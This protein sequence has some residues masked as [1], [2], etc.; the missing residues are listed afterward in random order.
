VR[1]HVR[2]GEEYR[3]LLED[4]GWTDVE[5]AELHKDDAVEGRGDLHGRALL[6]VARRPVEP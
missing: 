2:S 6:L 4:T 5:V 1:L 3:R